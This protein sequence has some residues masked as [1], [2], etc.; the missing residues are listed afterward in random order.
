MTVII[1]SGQWVKQAVC[2]DDPDA[3]FPDNNEAGIAYARSV[4]APCPVRRECLIDAI[5]TGDNEHGIRAGL[6]PCERR[7]VVKELAR[8]EQA[9]QAVAGSAA[10]QRGPAECGTNSGYR[11]HTRDKT[12]ICDP[13]RRAHADADAR[14]RRTGSTKAA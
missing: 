13:C 2:R 7:A 9:V 10:S 8:R 5:R 1:P 14:L 11:K 12:P 6:K 3:M 4:C